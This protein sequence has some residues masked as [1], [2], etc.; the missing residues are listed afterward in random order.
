[1]FDLEIDRVKSGEKSREEHEADFKKFKRKAGRQLAKE[2]LLFPLLS[3]PGFFHT[4]AANLTASVIR[5][6]WAHAVIFCGHF[7]EPTE[8]F[9]EERLD[10]ETK[11]EWYVRQ[12]LGSANLSG[13]PLFHIMTGNLSH[14]IEHHLFPDMPSNHYRKIAPEVREICDRYGLHYTTGPLHKQYFKVVRKIA[15][16]S[17]PGGHT[18]PVPG[19]T[20]REKVRRLLRRS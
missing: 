6:V 9:D 3:G 11:G 16:L 12:M 14:Q 8:T 18:E 20:K 15:R 19:E 2:Y 5:N 1:M 13:S 7:P 17:L 10:G 4:I